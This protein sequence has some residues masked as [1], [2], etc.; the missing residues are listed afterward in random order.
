[1][2]NAGEWDLDHAALRAMG[3]R[4]SVEFRYTSKDRKES[5]ARA[6]RAIGVK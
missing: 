3:I 6:E 5:N 4:Q 2:D 1:M